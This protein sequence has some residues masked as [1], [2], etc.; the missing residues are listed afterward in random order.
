MDFIVLPTFNPALQTPH[1]NGCLKMYRYICGTTCLV[2]PAPIIMIG[3]HYI[4][5]HNRQ[6]ELHDVL[7]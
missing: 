5:L 1:V 7:T 3:M 6:L 2:L 4:A